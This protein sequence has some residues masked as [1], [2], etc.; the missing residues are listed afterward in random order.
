MSPFTSLSRT[1]AHDASFVGMILMPYFLSNSM[2]EAITTDEQSVSGMKPI[3]T[4]FFSG[5]SDP[6]AQAPT[7]TASG[8]RLMS[9]AAPAFLRNSLLRTLIHDLPRQKK[10]RWELRFREISE[11]LRSNTTDAPL[12]PL[13]P[14]RQALCHQG[15][16]METCT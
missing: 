10:R 13:I 15:F 9:P 7:R 11:R 12:R 8:T 5:A 16:L 1:L 2:T 4:S 14:I 3:L 6:A